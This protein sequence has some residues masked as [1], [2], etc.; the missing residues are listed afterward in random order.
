MV[1]ANQG[2]HF[3][4]G[5]NIFAIAVA[6]QQGDYS[7]IDGAIRKMQGLLQ[8]LRYSPKTVVTAPFGMT[9]GGGCELV[10]ASSRAV[11]AAETYIGLVGVGVG[12]IPSGHRRKG[13]VGR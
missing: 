5:A 1:I 10:M 12:V 11:A 7:V 3:C 9:L 8:D 4:A 13:S 2:K 6:A